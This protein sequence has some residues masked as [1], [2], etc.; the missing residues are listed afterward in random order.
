MQNSNRNASG[1]P[2]LFRS[3]NR[4]SRAQAAGQG[5]AERAPSGHIRHEVRAIAKEIGHFTR[6]R[7]AE[8][9]G[10]DVMHSFGTEIS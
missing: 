2:S 4:S 5:L 9:S 10:N 3:E 8:Y 6:K 7:V 1:L